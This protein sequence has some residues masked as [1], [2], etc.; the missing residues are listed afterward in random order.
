M[1]YT[2][3][4]T[5]DEPCP[6][7]GSPD[8]AECE[9]RVCA[10]QISIGWEC[11]DCGHSMTWKTQPEDHA[12]HIVERRIVEVMPLHAI[13]ALYGERGL[14]ERFAAETARFGDVAGRRKAK[15]ALQLAGRLHALDHRQCEP[16]VNHLLRVALRIMCHYGVRDAGRYLRPASRGPR[17]GGHQPSIRVQ[18][19]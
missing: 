15:R 6:S 4:R 5:I 14:R 13:T 16:H 1:T 7:C 10:D 12:S 17:R 9:I 3:V 19:R 8:I 2:P 18:H 11:R